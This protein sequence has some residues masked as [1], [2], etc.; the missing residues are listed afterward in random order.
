MRIIVEEAR[1]KA[2]SNGVRETVIKLHTTLE[3]GLES[4]FGQN[5]IEQEGAH[6]MDFNFLWHGVKVI[7]LLLKY[8]YSVIVPEVPEVAL[9][10]RIKLLVNIFFDTVMVNRLILHFCDQVKPFSK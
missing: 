1:H 10:F 6:D 9:N 7:T 4:S 3:E 8:S 2:E 5:V